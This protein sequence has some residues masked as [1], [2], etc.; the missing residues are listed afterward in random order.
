MRLVMV[1]AILQLMLKLSASGF[2][3]TVQGST[4][5]KISLT[6]AIVSDIPP[7]DGIPGPQLQ[8]FRSS[9]P[10]SGSQTNESNLPPTLALPPLT[11]APVP[12][13]ITGLVPS[14][15]PS[16]QDVTTPT[17]IFQGHLPSLSPSIS[18]IS[19]TYNTAPPPTLSQGHEPPKPASANGREAPVTQ[20]PV[21]VSSAPVSAPPNGTLLRL[22]HSPAKDSSINASH[23][24]FPKPE[25]RTSPALSPSSAVVSG[26]TKNCSA[27]VCTE[28]YTNTPLGSS[29]GCVLPMQVGLSVSVALYTFF[30]L[31]SELAQEIAT[32]VFI[33]QS[34]VHIIGANAASQQP[35]KTIILIDLVPLEERFDNTTSLFIYQ[36]FWHKQ[37]VIN[38]SIFGDYEVL[39]VRYLGL[40]PSPPLAP[41][42]I[43]ITD[44]RPYSSDD[45]ARTGKPLGVDVHRKRK[46]GLGD[47]VIVIIAL[48]GFVALVLFSAIA[49]ALLFRHRDCASQPDIV[50]QPLPLSVVKPIGIAGSLVVS[51]H[52]SASLS[53]GSSIL[54]YTGFAKT[55]STSD[56]ERATNSFDAS[57]ILGEG[58]FGRVYRGILEDGTKVAVKVLKRDDQQGAREFLAEVEMLSRLHHRNLVKLIGI[59]TKE[60]S[61]SLVYE[62]VPNGSVESHL[63]GS[64][65]ALSEYSYLDRESSLR[66]KVNVLQHEYAYLYVAYLP[67]VDKES[68]SLDWD[69]RIKIAL[70][71]ARG[72]AY[73]HEDSSPF[74]I[75]RDFKSSNILLEHDFTP[76]VSDFGLA[77]TALDEENQHIST[78][79]MGTFGHVAPEYAM[80]GHL[81]VK[82]DVYSYGVVLLELL[83]GRKPVDM[84]QP[85]GQENLVAWAHPLLTSKEGL[86]LIIDPSLGFDVSFD[87]VAKVAVIASMCVQLEVSHRPFMGE[88]VQ[89]LKL[90]SNECNKARELD[91][92]S[93]SQVMS[94]DLDV[95]NNVVSGQLWGS[96]QNHALDS[97]PDI[98]RG[99]SV[100]D[101]FGTSVGYGRQGCGSLRRCSS[102][103]LRKVRGREL[104]RKMSLT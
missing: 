85:P 101:L 88:I 71:A 62:L 66:K 64:T 99:L 10:R 9:A 89:A 100:L 84:S 67:G 41:S 78:R 18:V 54:V 29:C 55:F 6:P 5:D 56:I 96:F 16:P 7:I 60:R 27:T 12:Q 57:R 53:F 51:G 4:G 37:V 58:V 8:P 23:Y 79:V 14:H 82:S 102:G 75:H 13:T 17:L 38:P 21:S 69:A 87:S 97:E 59:C 34:Q 73:L 1:P 80:T 3:F 76:K 93:S 20:I 68:T 94:I 77:R 24:P 42:G 81:L 15:S 33:K 95:E 40:P 31:V 30:P 36:R 50:L 46:N 72:L 28:P 91:S 52:S 70:G 25:T 48:S 90:V 83:T 98:E 39:Y 22:S 11:S 35:K 92:I 45:N 2:V 32:G 43:A 49:W 47:G 104:L 74:V 44:D 63:H 26:W 65:L 19:P 61:R 103:P 86:K